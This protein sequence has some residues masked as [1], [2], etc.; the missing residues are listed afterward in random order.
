MLAAGDKS[1]ADLLATGYGPFHDALRVEVQWTYCT[2]PKSWRGS[3][4]A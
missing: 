4:V 2:L 3:L 1:I